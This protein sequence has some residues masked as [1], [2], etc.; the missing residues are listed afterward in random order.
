MALCPKCEEDY[1]ALHAHEPFCDGTK[2]KAARGGAEPTASEIEAPERSVLARGQ[3]AAAAP[4]W[5]AV[6]VGPAPMPESVRDEASKAYN[7]TH[8]WYFAVP[9]VQIDGLGCPGLPLDV[10]HSSSSWQPHQRQRQEDQ[11]SVL[12][13]PIQRYGGTIAQSPYVHLMPVRDETWERIVEQW[14]AIIPQ[15]IAVEQ[16]LLEQAEADLERSQVDRGERLVVRN[17]IRVMSTRIK[18][19][20]TLDFDRVRKFFDQEHTFSRLYS[21]S[22]AQMTRDMVGDLV[23]EEFERR[24]G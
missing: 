18:Q 5:R 7:V 12:V 21:R 20:E 8:A 15:E 13:M 17:R 16:D 19:L 6:R 9:V 11:G 22:S 2:K 14:T 4:S 23:T 24:A 1:Q 10:F 3:K